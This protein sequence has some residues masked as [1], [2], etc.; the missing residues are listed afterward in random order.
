MNFRAGNKITDYRNA[1][2]LQQRNDISR[3][4][5]SELFNRVAHRYDLLNRLLS[6]RRDV[7][8]RKKLA[9]RLPS[10]SEM[11]VLDLA[12]G[13]G[14][15]ILSALSNC[16]N[17]SLVVGLDPAGEMLKL[18]QRKITIAGKSN[19][20]SLVRADALSLPFSDYSFDVVTIA[21][22]IRNV[23][24]VSRAFNEILRVLKPGGAVVVLE[25]SLPSCRF[26]RGIYLLYFRHILPR[27]GAFIS[28]EANAYTYLNTS[29]E[30]FPYGRE[31]CD[32]MTHSGFEQTKSE[33]LTFG[34]ATLYTGIKPME[35]N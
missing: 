5:I 8:W 21:F 29:V 30:K 20:T 16:D 35:S 34:V 12:T 33:P 4:K 11:T 24:D 26:L 23:T 14:D 1:T 2:R 10:T 22:G 19:E 28:G 17:I 7:A 9:K 32:L 18:A 3:D 13:T 15:V 27:L 31:F 6:A 25:F